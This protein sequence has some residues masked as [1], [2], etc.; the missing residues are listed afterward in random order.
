MKF[1]IDIEMRDRLVKK[2]KR[3]DV[4]KDKIARHQRT[5]CP[6]PFSFDRP[7]LRHYTVFDG[8]AGMQIEDIHQDR[9]GFLWI[10]TADGGLCRFDGSQFDSFA[11]PHG[12]PHPTVMGIAETEDGTL[13]FATLAAR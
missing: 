5:G 6:S 12:L 13:W 4:A 7:L 1:P 9:R 3:F 8:L 11:E 2:Q 10:A